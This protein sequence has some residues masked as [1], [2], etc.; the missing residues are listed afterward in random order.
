MKLLVAL[1]LSIS[2]AVSAVVVP[3][4]YYTVDD[5]E[6]AYIYGDEHRGLLPDMQKYQKTVV[7]EYEKEF[8]LKM[9]DKLSVGLATSENQIANG[10]S[11]QIPFNMQLFYGAGASYIDYF[12]FSSW[13]K[14][15]VVHETAHN[16]QLNPKENLLSKTGH[17]LLGNNPVTFLGLFPIFPIPNIME[18]S[19][20][21]E[22]NAVLNESRF[23]NGGRLFSGYALAEVVALAN[24]GKI[25]PQLMYN[26]T[27]EFP[28][29]EK[30]YL[31]GGF[32]QQFL[33]K[34]YGIEKVNG[35]FKRFAAQPFPFFTNIMFKKQFGKSFEVLLAEFVQEIKIKHKDAKRTEG[36]LLAKSQ[37]FVPFNSSNGEIYTLVGDRKSAPEILLLNKAN[38]SMSFE[39]GAWREGEV[40]RA[41]GQ[42]YTQSS[43][44]TSPVKIEMGLF[45]ASGFMEEKFAS[46]ALQG[47]TS[48]GKA[49]YFD[50][51]S[52]IETPQVYVDGKFYTQSH[53]SVHVQGEDLYYF[54]QEGEKR[55][56]FKN[57]EALYSY[58]GHYGFVTDVDSKGAVYYV[59]DT[60]HGS[61]VYKLLNG[62]SSRVSLGDDIIDFKLTTNN[63]ALVATMTAKGYEYRLISL[64]ARPQEASPYSPS[65]VSVNK[66]Q[67]ID[68][69][70]FE[71][72]TTGTKL[73]EDAYASFTSLRYS[74]LEPFFSYTD[75]DG[76]GVDVAATFS[77]PLFQNQLSLLGSHNKKRDIA[78]LVYDNT[79]FRLAFGGAVYGVSKDNQYDNSDKRDSG[80]ELYA[81]F[82]WL[83]SGYW[84]ADSTLAYTKAYY[85]IYRKPLTFSLDV[86]N[87]KQYAFSKYA[88]E[89]NDLSLFISEDRE[90]QMYG[91][92][93]TFKHDLFWQSYVG[94]KATY[95]K[96]DTIDVFDE[97][98]IELDNT[99]SNLQSDKA[100]LDIPSFTFRTYAKEVK[101]GEVS[102]AKVFDGSLYLY[103]LPLSLQRESIY[104]K[105]RRYEIDFTNTF[106]RTYDETT[107]GMEF[108]FLFLHKYTVPL[109]VEWIHNKDVIDQNQGRILIGGSF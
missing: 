54:K 32:F 45:D 99:F 85:N 73:K 77:D 89:S 92:T 13:L 51:K 66:N 23:G 52:S 25:T 31:V 71:K 22:G 64:N 84:S 108:D 57:R 30:F 39:S 48:S 2:L 38:K 9:D 70:T 94:L 10:F 78:G 20:I 87:E 5:G 103:S 47:F 100:T 36:K 43:A 8:N 24:A 26:S 67:A 63:E 90:N 53:S 69:S 37:L 44:K 109:S 76:F 35:Y 19:F 42:F 46:K 29:G 80:Y 27:L 65:I 75:T 97:K 98:G 16:F 104:A 86:A 1:S 105:Q 49:V 28:Y 21:L 96:S 74:A 6:F 101:M 68:N 17:T 61:S 56:L 82:P 91:G 107:V 34:R 79:A 55:T 81:T 40:F 11:T 58:E 60:E 12:C 18:S 59:A 93:Y 62:K 102:L 15:L 4:D 33:A 14:T 95:L 41:N 106:Q 3:D 50:I 7:G 72:K 88:N 83:E